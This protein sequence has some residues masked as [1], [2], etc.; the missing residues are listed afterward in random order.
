M[1]QSLTGTVCITNEHK[2][3][4]RGI[5]LTIMCKADVHW[6]Q[7]NKRGHEVKYMNNS[8]LLFKELYVHG[9]GKNMFLRPGTFSYPFEIPIVSSGKHQLP[10][11]MEF[12]NGSVRYTIK[13][14]VDWPWASVQDHER[15]IPVIN[16][17]N[18]REHKK[19]LQPVTFAKTFSGG[20]QWF[21]EITIA[22]R[23]E[24]VGYVPGEEILMNVEIMNKSGTR[25]SMAWS[26]LVM[27]VKYTASDGSE[28]T[29]SKT[30]VRIDYGE[31]VGKSVFVKQHDPLLIPPVVQSGEQPCGFLNV[32]YEIAIH[33]LGRKASHWIIIGTL[34]TRNSYRRFHPLDLPD[35]KS[36]EWPH[37]DIRGVPYFEVVD[38][39]ADPDAW[40]EEREAIDR[41]YRVKVVNF[42]FDRERAIREYDVISD[43][44]DDGDDDD[45]V[46]EKFSEISL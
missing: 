43:G 42:Q 11:S 12:P 46:G 3:R 14:E 26:E 23:L 28:H 8:N 31:V 39:V 21:K 30:L 24:K 22:G 18:L 16:P 33:A 17:F 19:S 34:P 1:G 35:P 38:Q 10:S 37:P 4:M 25:I 27:H 9:D 20:S 5:K 13:A 41:D 45:D 29:T 2:R 36:C 44:E 32:T 40:S 6:H 15:F 7:K